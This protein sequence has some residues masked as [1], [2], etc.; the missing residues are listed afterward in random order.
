V[1][2]VSSAAEAVDVSQYAWKA[3]IA[4]S[5]TA[6]TAAVINLVFLI[7]LFLSDLSLE[8]AELCPLHG[9]FS[10]SFTI[11]LIFF[12]SGNRFFACS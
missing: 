9:M 2:D 5:I 1:P 12:L 3:V 7:I 10:L 11:F 8:T 4:L 6:Q